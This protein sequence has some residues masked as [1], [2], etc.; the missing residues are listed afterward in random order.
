M[1]N[2]LVR[3]DP[4][5]GLFP[6]SDGR[7]WREFEDMFS[8]LPGYTNDG[9]CLTQFPKSNVF[10][11][12]NG[13]YVELALAGYSKEQ[14][15][16]K[17]E[18]NVLLVSAAKKEGDSTTRFASRAFSQKFRIGDNLDI[19]KVEAKFENGLLSIFIP[20]KEEEKPAI[21]TVEIQ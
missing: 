10:A 12:E 19:N 2:A 6:L 14:L 7:L 20:R 4:F 13:T 5:R 17:I 8:D 9:W 11:E 15:D 16:I 1:T 21:K 3:L 18:D